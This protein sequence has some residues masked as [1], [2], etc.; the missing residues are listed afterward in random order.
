V[1]RGVLDE[2]DKA[3]APV[4]PP[5]IRAAGPPCLVNTGSVK[6]KILDTIADTGNSATVGG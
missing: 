5:Q 4:Q 6:H 3:Q 1:H 2:R